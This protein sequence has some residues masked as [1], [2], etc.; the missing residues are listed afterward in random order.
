MCKLVVRSDFYEELSIPTPASQKC[1]FFHHALV[2]NW[3][4]TQCYFRGNIK[5][6]K[7]Y[8][9][10]HILV[11][12]SEDPG[13]AAAYRHVAARLIKYLEKV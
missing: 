11:P 4:K 13:E 7:I 5:N 2:Q 6:I 3:S 10:W 1:S 12:V 9:L 8:I